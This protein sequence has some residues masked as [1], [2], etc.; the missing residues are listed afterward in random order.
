MSEYLKNKNVAY[1]ILAVGV[2]VALLSILI[3]PIR[4]YDIYMATS[5]IIGLI[6]G[7]VVALVGVYLAF[8]VKPAG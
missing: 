8:M 2:I 4:G 3:D 5:Q 7:I 1:G 6:V